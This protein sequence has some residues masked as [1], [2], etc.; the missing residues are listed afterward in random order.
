MKERFSMWG[1]GVTHGGHRRICIGEECWPDMLLEGSL[2]RDSKILLQGRPMRWLKNCHV[3]TRT[4]ITQYGTLLSELGSRL[5][6]PP[7]QHV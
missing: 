1:T 3:T 6:S 7:P 4:E 5:S 2:A